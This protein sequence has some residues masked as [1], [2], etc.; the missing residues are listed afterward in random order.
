M[1]NKPLIKF[2]IIYGS[3]AAV[4][5]FFYIIILDKVLLINPLGGKKETGIIVL[6][7]AMILAVIQ[8]RAANGGGLE[9]GK[10]YMVCFATTIWASLLS[11]VFLYLFLNFIAPNCLPE[12]IKATS[13][14]LLKNKGQIIKN[15]ISEQDYNEAYKNIQTTN[16]KSILIDDFIKKIFL[17]IIPSFMISLYFRRRFLPS[18]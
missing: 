7:G 10:G 8:V 16:I 11:L 6:I 2:P 1:L 5:I 14:E 18:K 17:S 3:L 9:L 4:F 13:D 12:Y 15:G